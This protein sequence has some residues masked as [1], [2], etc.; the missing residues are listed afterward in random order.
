[1]AGRT[2]VLLRAEALHRATGSLRWLSALLASRPLRKV[3]HTPSHIALPRTLAVPCSCRLHLPP[4][5]T[6]MH[7]VST[8]STML[9]KKG[10]SSHDTGIS[11]VRPPYPN[12]HPTPGAVLPVPLLPPAHLRTVSTVGTMILKNGRSGGGL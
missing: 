11:A 1:M 6:H 9:L 2:A 5:R 10:R 8:A 7:T 12:P 3:G 4:H